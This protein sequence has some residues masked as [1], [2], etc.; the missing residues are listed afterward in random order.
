MKLTN[1]A[2]IAIAGFFTL[3]RGAPAS[4]SVDNASENSNLSPALVSP[5]HVTTR[6]L[7]SSEANLDEERKDLPPSTRKLKDGLWGAEGNWNWDETTHKWVNETAP[8]MLSKRTNDCEKENTNPDMEYSDASPLVSDC[9]ML[10][11]SNTLGSCAFGAT[12]TLWGKTAKVG[13]DDIWQ[14]VRAA[15]STHTSKNSKGETVVAASGSM[16]CQTETDSKWAYLTWGLY[17]S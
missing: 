15:L 3:S 10:A 8:K 14:N 12:N 5:V 17:H 11:D 9:K 16:S 4:T 1:T 2:A 7:R 6:K 13:N